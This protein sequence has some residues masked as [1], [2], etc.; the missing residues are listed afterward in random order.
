MYVWLIFI[1][2]FGL[3]LG[4]FLGVFV[5]RYMKEEKV[6]RGRSKCDH[7]GQQ[8]R[9]FENIPLLS[10]LLQNRRCRHCGHYLSVFYPAIELT[11]A[12]SFSVYFLAITSNFPLLKS[13]LSLPTANFPVVDVRYLLIVPA[14]VIIASLIS[15]FFSDLLYGLI[16]DVAVVV[17]IISTLLL[18]FGNFG[19]QASAFRQTLLDP[20]NKLGPALLANGFYQIHVQYYFLGPVLW[21]IG[22][23]I[24]LTL[25]F[26]LLVLITRGRG[27][28]LGDVKFAFLL[29]L[30]VGWPNV[31]VASFLAFVTGALW[32]VLL[33]L[34]KRTHF[35]QAIHFGPF[36]VLSIPL[37]LLFGDLIIRW[38]LKI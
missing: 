30:I 2:T 11:T 10:W 3:C 8:L 4:S 38:Y 25:F 16:P 34:T 22:G 14:F 12:L 27:M 6:T 18:K 35:G 32:T 15:I 21:D 29:G 28:G 20:A 31:V 24:L 7:C 33:L 13:S 23:A 19:Y 37:A 17:G 26:L 5:V 9:W 36:L 1:F